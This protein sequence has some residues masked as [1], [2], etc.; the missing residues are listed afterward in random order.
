MSVAELGIALSVVAFLITHT[1]VVFRWGATLTQIVKAHEK[2][3][4]ELK[5]YHEDKIAPSIFRVDEMWR[6]RRE[7]ERRERERRLTEEHE[8]PE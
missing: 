1:A 4:A 5:S 7:R 3:I 6:E 2:D 8:T